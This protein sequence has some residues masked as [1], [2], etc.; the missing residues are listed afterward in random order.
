[1]NANRYIQSDTALL[2]QIGSKMR[3][4][5]LEKNITQAKLQGLSGVYRTTIGDLENGKNCSLLVLIQLLR[6][7]ERLD[8]LD[9]FF[10]EQMPSPVLYA[11]LHRMERLRASRSTEHLSVAEPEVKYKKKSEW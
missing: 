11:K 1:M 7:L 9:A 5:R 8:L 3:K 2:R 6:A 4:A 10:E